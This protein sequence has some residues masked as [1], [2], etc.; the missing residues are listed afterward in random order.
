MNFTKVKDRAHC[1]SAIL[2]ES[3]M[4]YVIGN[5]YPIKDEIKKCGGK[6]DG[7]AWKVPNE[8]YQEIQSLL[9]D[10]KEIG[11]SIQERG[12][13]GRIRK[14]TV[15]QFSDTYFYV[16]QDFRQF[17]EFHSELREINSLHAE[18]LCENLTEAEK[19]IIF[20]F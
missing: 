11:Y 10:A 18:E 9:G 16:L 1:N 3:P 14:F 12:A 13:E 15:F 20:N 6:W 17:N 19:K 5:T 8:K 4:K 7:Q 2:K